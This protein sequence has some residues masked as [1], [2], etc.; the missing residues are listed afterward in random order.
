[1]ERRETTGSPSPGLQPDPDSA[2]PSDDEPATGP[3]PEPSLAARLA[4]SGRPGLGE[5]RPATEPVPD[6][7]E[8]GLG[9]RMR[10]G[11]ESAPRDGRVDAPGVTYGPDPHRER[12]ASVPT[13]APEESVGAAMSGPAG[14]RGARGGARQAEAPG[15][16]IES[17][18]T[19]REEP[20]D[21]DSR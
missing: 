16:G 10:E 19:D 5:E 15:S 8:T 3:G 7:Q 18:A 17:Q 14:P 21:D 4:R 6:D 2:M 9:E 1:M 11:D 12:I 13:G 20:D